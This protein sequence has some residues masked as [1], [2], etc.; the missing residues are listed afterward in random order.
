MERSFQ[1]HRGLKQTF[2][3]PREGPNLS[4]ASENALPQSF[5]ALEALISRRHGGLSS[6]L[7]DIAAFALTHP[8]TVALETVAG[9]AERAGVAPSALVRFAQALGFEGFSD[10]QRVFRERLVRLQ[11]PYR[12]RIPPGAA[13][14]VLER[15]VQGGIEAL[16]RL[17]RE[18]PAEA[19]EAAAKRIADARRVG[20][21][22]RR[23]SFPVAAYLAYGL[24]HLGKPTLLLDGAGG[25]PEL[26]VATLGEGDLLIAVSFKPYAP[27]TLG[28]AVRAADAG[29]P[30]LALTDGP[31][32]PLVP[33]AEAT[34]FLRE[35]EHAGVRSLSASMCL[36][37]SLIV[38]AGARLAEGTAPA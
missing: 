32:S 31:L 35:A 38:A 21:V 26:E 5:A 3:G 15:F 20:V 6:R 11:T 4:T 29:V 8:E 17:G 22:A 37:V 27:E 23:R 18:V 33:L 36:A 25:F 12:E 14:Q 30:L 2:Q 9:V 28:L 10:M 16:E 19:L 24:L 34:L 7:K 1:G 13:P